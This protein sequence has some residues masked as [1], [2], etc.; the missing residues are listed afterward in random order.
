[1][2]KKKIKIKHRKY[3]LYQ[4][5]KSTGRKALT[6]ILM[7]VVV[8]ALV[9]VGYGIGRPL[10]EYFSGKS[11]TP[12]TSSSAWTPPV[13][14][15]TTADSAE[16]TADSADSAEPTAESTEAAENTSVS[17]YILPEG[18]TLN[19]DTLNSALAAAKSAGYTDIAVTLKDETGNFLYKTALDISEDQVAGSLTAKQIV[20]LI[21]SAGLTPRARINTLLDSTTQVYGGEYICYMITDGSVWHDYYVNQGGKSWLDPFNDGT[22]AFLSAVTAELAQAGF[23][24]VI[25]ANTRLPVFNNQDYSNFLQNMPIADESSRLEALWNVISACTAAAKSSGA[26]ILLEMTDEELLASDKALTTAEPAGDKTKLKTVTLLVD[27]NPDDTASYINARAFAGQLTGM[28][29]GQSI[30]IRLTSSS[31]SGSTLDDVRQ[32]FTDAG[33]A[34][35]SE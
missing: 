20:Q 18:A 10:M 11:E 14:S 30:A 13:S 5:K 8:A 19:S 6:V 2:K 34:V 16:P 4:R 24:S 1:M 17:A 9:V 27:Y 35:Y 32:A 12:D 26:E 29:S 25:L 21:T 31:F 7:I 15:E 33:M 23:E 22:S 3:S 28:Y